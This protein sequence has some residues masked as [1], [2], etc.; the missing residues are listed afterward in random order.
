MRMSVLLSRG[1]IGLF[2]LYTGIKGFMQ[3][4]DKVILAATKGV[5][6]ASVVVPISLLLLFIAGLTIITGY[7]MRFGVVALAL[8]I[9]PVTLFVHDF[10]SIA[11]PLRRIAEWNGLQSNLALLAYGEAARMGSTDARA[12]PMCGRR[13][14]YW[15]LAR[16][17]MAAAFGS[18]FERAVQ[19]HRRPSAGRAGPSTRRRGAI[20]SASPTPSAARARRTRRRVGE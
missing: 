6:A 1:I 19:V 13:A 14:R 7:E 9:L 10:W 8:V 3:L 4:D 11:E 12:R 18:R 15:R 5:P 16:K 2:Y 17:L 20:T